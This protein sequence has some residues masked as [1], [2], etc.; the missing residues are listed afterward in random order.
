MEMASIKMEYKDQL[1]YSD[2]DSF[3][4]S[5]PLPENLVNNKLGAWKLEY[6]I[7]K[8]IFLAPKVYALILED[9]S[10][11]VKVKGSKVNFSFLDMKDLLQKDTF[12]EMRQEKWY[13]NMAKGNI[14]I[15]EE[16]YTLSATENKREFVYDS[17][18][19]IVDTKPL[20]ISD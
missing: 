12:L 18:N 11:I 6:V 1:Y 7:K 10:E 13:K 9:G 5:V 8:A 15:K 4:S 14:S 17:N 2:T 3:F 16:I 19:K 20:I